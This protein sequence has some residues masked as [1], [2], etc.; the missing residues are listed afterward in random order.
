MKYNIIFYDEYMPK[1]DGNYKNLNKTCFF[2]YEN[3]ESAKQG[4]MYGSTGFIVAIQS[5]KAGIAYIYA[6]TNKHCIQNRNPVLRFNGKNNELVYIQTQQ[7]DWYSLDYDVAVCE[8]H[9]DNMKNTDFKFIDSSLFITNNVLSSQS[10]SEGEDCFMIGRFVNYDGNINYNKPSMRFGN[11]SILDANIIH[12]YSTQYPN[13]YR[14]IHR[15]HLLDMRARTGYSGSPVFVYRTGTSTLS[16]QG[17]SIGGNFLGLLGIQWGIIPDN[18]NDKNIF[19]NS[20]LECN[21]HNA[22]D[23]AN[24][25]I[26]CSADY[27]LETLNIPILQNRRKEANDMIIKAN[28]A[29]LTTNTLT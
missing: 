9:P 16:N 22:N 4:V 24:M 21:S 5:I 14:K 19:N 11:I 3:I 27:I 10:I 17:I 20:I 23:L 25:S 8:L 7:N 6:I 2:I 1:F 26:V 28:S 18:V 12:P 15:S 29:Q 13:S